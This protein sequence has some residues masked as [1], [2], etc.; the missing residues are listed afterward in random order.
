MF[1]AL[2][3]ITYI[4]PLYLRSETPIEGEIWTP[5]INKQAFDELKLAKLPTVKNLHVRY[6]A[7]EAEKKATYA[8][9]RQ[10]R[11]DMR[12]LLTAKANVDRLMGYDT[13]KSEKEKEQERR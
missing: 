6:V 5:N 9:Y 4:A 10:A 11:E 8:A 7:L 3:E 12:N 13:H 2:C 1:S